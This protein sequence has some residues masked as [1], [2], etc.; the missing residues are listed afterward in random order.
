VPTASARQAE[1]QQQ[2]ITFALDVGVS[3]RHV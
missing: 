1:V 3:L 2:A